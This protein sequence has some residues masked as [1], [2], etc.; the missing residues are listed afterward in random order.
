MVEEVK[1]T[2]HMKDKYRIKFP[3]VRIPVDY[4]PNHIIRFKPDHR[5]CNRYA[6]AANVQHWSAIHHRDYISSGKGTHV[7]Y[8]NAF[9]NASKAY[10]NQL[11]TFERCVEASQEAY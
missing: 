1:K 3:L 4:D 5:K 2:T 8:H 11:R 10:F 7:N 6:N 9:K